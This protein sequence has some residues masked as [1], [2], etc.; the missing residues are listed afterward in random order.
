MR[1]IG[2]QKRRHTARGDDE[3]VLTDEALIVRDLG[4]RNG[5]FLNGER[6]QTAH[7]Q[8]GSTLRVG[9]VDLVVSEA[10][11]HI[12]VPDIAV[13]APP[14]PATFMEDGSPCCARH[15]GVEAKV[16]CSSCQDVFCTGCVRKLC[17]AG[18]TPRM[19]CPACGNTCQPLSPTARQAKRGWLGR[20]VD[21]FTK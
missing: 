6:I 17:V 11:A 1:F 15:P 21:V 19:F 4:S 3:L 13:A 8:T 20:I 12:S 18:G 5:T 16:Q 2:L 14:P 10:P 9:D 7:V